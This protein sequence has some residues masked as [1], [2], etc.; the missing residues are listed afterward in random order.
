M[1]RGGG[2]TR[3]PTLVVKSLLLSADAPQ[4][5]GADMKHPMMLPTLSVEKLT[6]TRYHVMMDRLE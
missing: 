1:M 6:L 2:L 4:T 5:G 3:H